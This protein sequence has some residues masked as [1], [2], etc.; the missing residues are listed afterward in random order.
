MTSRN[1]RNVDW[2]TSNWLTYLPQRHFKFIKHSITNCNDLEICRRLMKRVLTSYLRRMWN[3]RDWLTHPRRRVLSRDC[4]NTWVFVGNLMKSLC[5]MKVVVSSCNLW[6]VGILSQCESFYVWKLVWLLRKI[7]PMDFNE[8]WQLYLAY[9]RIIYTFYLV[10]GAAPLGSWLNRWEKL[11]QNKE[12]L[13]SGVFWN[14]SL[15][16]M[17]ESSRYSKSH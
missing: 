2:H 3:L 10:A 11:V 16:L 8:N 17:I 15:A 6:I 7:Y 14:S 5:M 12:S 9:T 13:V 4:S 1:I